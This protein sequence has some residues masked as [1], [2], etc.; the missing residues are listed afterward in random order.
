VPKKLASLLFRQVGVEE[1]PVQK[2]EGET[3][4]WEGSRDQ[5]ARQGT[6]RR[7]SALFLEH[8][9]RRASRWGF[10]AISPAPSTSIKAEPIKGGNTRERP[11]ELL[12]RRRTPRGTSA[13][14]YKTCSLL[15][16][17]LIES[18]NVR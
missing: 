1:G 13:A 3:I 2:Q 8:F 6:L 7:S 14:W 18:H 4:N 10:R 16:C 12:P 9:L 17:P 15:I 11:A 5:A